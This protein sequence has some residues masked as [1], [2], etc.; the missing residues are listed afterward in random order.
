MTATI[1]SVRQQAF[2]T[3]PIRLCALG[4]L[5]AQP[6]RRINLGQ[7]REWK[8]RRSVRAGLRR[9]VMTGL[10]VQAG[11]ILVLLLIV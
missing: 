9:Q 10:L 3:R 5:Q 8:R 11:L 7:W 4:L 2:P 1:P 6:R